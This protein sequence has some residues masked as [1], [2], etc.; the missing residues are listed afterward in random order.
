[1]PICMAPKPALHAKKKAHDV[2]YNDHGF[3]DESDTYDH[4]V[5]N[6]NGGPA[7]YPVSAPCCK[8]LSPH[9]ELEEEPF[10]S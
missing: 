3:P 5:H 6:I 7:I 2:F 10:F 9:I 4:L 8:S 1:M